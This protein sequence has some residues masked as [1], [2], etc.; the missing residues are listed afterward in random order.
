LIKLPL[1]VTHTISIT[2]QKKRESLP[3]RLNDIHMKLKTTLLITLLSFIIQQTSLFAQCN[4]FNY[5][6]A[7]GASTVEWINNFELGSINNTSGNNGGYEDFTNLSTVLT[8]GQTYSLSCTPGY[9]DFTFSQVFQVYI[10]YNSDGDFTDSG[11][12][13]FQSDPVTVTTTS[14]FTVPVTAIPV[15]TALRVVMRFN[16][17]LGPCGDIGFGE[18]EDYCVTIDGGNGCYQAP[19]VIDDITD[20]GATANWFDVPSAESYNFRYREVGAPTWIE[21]NVTSNS[22]AMNLQGCTV[23]EAQ[24][25]TLCPM[26]LSSGY[27]ASIE[28]LTFGCGNCLDLTYCANS[29]VFVL[30]FIESVSLNTWTNTSGNNNGL[31]DFTGPVVT[32]LEQGLNYDITVTQGFIDFNYGSWFTAYIDFNADGDFDDPFEKIMDSDDSFTDLSFTSN[33]PVPPTAVVGTTRLRVFAQTFAGLAADPCGTFFN[34]EVEDYCI[35]ITAGTGCYLPLETAVIDNLGESI[36]IGWED[37]LTAESYSIRYRTIGSPTWITITNIPGTANTYELMNLQECNSYE[38]QLMTVCDAGLSTPWSNSYTIVTFGCGA[39]LDVPYCE[40]SNAFVQSFIESVSL[41]SWTNTSGNNDGIADFTGPVAV[42]GIEQ[43]LSYNITVTQGFIDFNYGSW[44]TAYIDFNADGD[45]DDPFEKIMDSNEPLTNLFFTSEFPVPPT[46]VVG[47]TRLRVFAQT[48]A[49]LAAD[50]CGEFFNGE[51]EDY[52][53]QITEGTGCYLPLETAVIENLGESVVIGWEDGLTAESYS[54]RYRTIGSPFWTT[55]TNLPGT[56]N[57]YELMGLEEC[58]DY[59]FQLMTLCDAGLST[60]WSSSY[61]FTT[62]GCGACFDFTYCEALASSTTFEYIGNVTFGDLNNTSGNNGGYINFEDQFQVTYFVDSTYNMVLTPSW[63]SFMYQVAW[64]VWID[65]NADGD[66]EDANEMVFEAAPSIAVQVASITIPA[67]A[68]FGLT[69]MRVSMPE[70]FLTGPCESFFYGEVEDYCITIAPVVF[71]CLPPENL[72]VA[73]TSGNSAELVWE[74]D[75]YETA[76]GYILRYKLV[77]ETEWEQ[78]IS[79][80]DPNYPLFGLEFCKDYEYQVS[81]VCP[82]SF[83]EYAD[84]F[85]FNTCISDTEEDTHFESISSLSVY[86]NP[87][88]DRI[89]LDFELQKASP[90]L[91]QLYNLN[92]QLVQVLQSD[93]LSTGEQRIEL[94]TAELSAGMYLIQL[95]TEEDVVI[96]KLVKN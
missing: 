32:S 34:G 5:C 8:V 59:E 65:Y 77:D 43:G 24:V 19:I 56:A 64:R 22:F 29:N 94:L 37:G 57:T 40:N 44:F 91:I 11:E 18:V 6:S 10:D 16:S 42:T 20:T 95:A 96:R 4:A 13:V 36:V 46:A 41:N 74:P 49:G 80:N 30:S 48:F 50:P 66:F 62:F 87:F 63:P 25:E 7:N 3:I 26:G 23:Y 35:E 83:S 75:L 71:P 17:P 79:T 90:V 60:S 61:P 15:T 51:V 58:M 89:Q 9:A 72:G 84:P 88:T 14:T 76:I 68:V 70:F 28:F 81:A 52:C 78:E 86:P 54:L 73:A 45:F 47:S 31:A 92:G 93:Q 21:T 1:I 2:H 69:K 85:E 82:Q 55:L 12:L 67:D 33:F 38:F 53:I 39:C 27:G